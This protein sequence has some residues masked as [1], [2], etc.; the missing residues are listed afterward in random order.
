MGIFWAITLTVLFRRVYQRLLKL[1]SK[2]TNLAS[3]A[4]VFLVLLLFIIP[5]S[6]L[7]AAVISEG[8]AIVLLVEEGDVDIQ[9]QIRSLA[10]KV[11]AK[12]IEWGLPVERIFDTVSSQLQNL[13]QG[14]GQRLLRFTQGVLGFGVQLVV[15][16]YLLFFFL[17]DGIEIME[18]A[19]KASPLK[20]QKERKLLRRFDA[21]VRATMKGSLLI[22]IIQGLL[23]GILFTAVGV[24]GAVILGSLMVIASLLPVGGILIWGPVAAVLFA[25]G[26]MTKGII[27]VVV[28]SL[29]IGLIDNLLRPHLVAS[30]TKMPDYLIL[31]STLGGLSWFGLSGLVIGPIIAA[32]FITSWEMMSEEYSSEQGGSD[33]I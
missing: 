8:Q 18:A 25:Q 24:Q 22:A 5:A 12:L 33:M 27:V 10:D 6:I 4:T 2:R 9:E 13:A 3:A 32:F 23:G 7:V 28:G 11:P 17:R 20:D 30:G 15:A 19:L 21:V 14:S 31:I 16:L 29:M 26:D 1:W